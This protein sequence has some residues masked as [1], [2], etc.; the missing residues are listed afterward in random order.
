MA[1][2]IAPPNRKLREIILS[3]T[4]PVQGPDLV[5]LVSKTGRTD[6]G[7]QRVVNKLIKEGKVVNTAGHYSSHPALTT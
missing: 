1:E 7:V 6:R 2:R 4:R 3:L 5:D